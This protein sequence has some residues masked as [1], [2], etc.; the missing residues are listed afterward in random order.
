[1]VA[2]KSTLASTLVVAAALPA[3]LANPSEKLAARDFS[4]SQYQTLVN[5]DNWTDSWYRTLPIFF[6]PL[7][8]SKSHKPISLPFISH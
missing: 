6:P 8:F 2:I 1:M 7:A 3:V 4:A 5:G